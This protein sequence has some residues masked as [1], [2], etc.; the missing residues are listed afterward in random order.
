[1]KKN[2]KT[3]CHII[4]KK[5]ITKRRGECRLENK[6]IAL[7][8]PCYNEASRGDCNNNFAS[9]LQK[10]SEELDKR[11]V[12]NVVLV[13]D[14]SA[15]NTEEV[16]KKFIESN[17]LSKDWHLISLKENCG[18]GQALIEGLS[19]AATLA[20]YIAYIDADLSVPARYLNNVQKN[21]T[22]F[23]ITCGYRRYKNQPL[24]RK[25]ANKLAKTCNKYA[26]GVNSK[27][28]Q[29][30]F[31]VMPS[32][33][34]LKVKQWLKG[35]RWIFDIE[36]LWELEKRGYYLQETFVDFENM[37]SVSLSTIKALARCA[38]DI[39]DFKATR[40]VRRARYVAKKRKE[41]GV[42]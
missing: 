29:C 18:K 38:L 34:F 39:V 5:E 23:N 27:D 17:G 21:C 31:K 12:T 41:G 36:L 32:E 42:S 26:I 10:L 16:A 19:L 40:W 6:S 24:A 4:T 14:G 35:Y 15:D 22:K 37:E 2:E 20:P 9:R 30:P 8:V 25:V 13:N 7:V 11:V 28:T 33:G 3:F 1:M